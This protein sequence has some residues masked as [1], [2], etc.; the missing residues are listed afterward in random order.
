MFSLDPASTVFVVDDDRGARDSVAALI[1]IMGLQTKAYPTAEAFLTDNAHC[2]AGC[3][4]ADLRMPGMSGIGMLKSMR[5]DGS[6]MPF[7]LVTAYADVPIAVEA[8]REGA[9]TILEKPYRQQVLWDFIVLA[10]RADYD[11]RSRAAARVDLLDRIRELSSEETH[12]LHMMVNDIPNKV[13]ASRLQ[14]SLRTVD[15][16][17]MEILE[18][19]RMENLKSLIWHLGAAGWPMAFD[20]SEMTV[21]V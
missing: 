14:I 13:I 11:R 9:L 19:L 3:V 15:H 4:I 5:R 1:R 2:E 8:L 10:L 21:P 16:R 12:V 6:E 18:K 7:I 20:R 17:R